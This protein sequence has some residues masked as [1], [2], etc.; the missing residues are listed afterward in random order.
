[1]PNH[2][3]GVCEDD[4]VVQ[5]PV[6]WEWTNPAAAGSL[7]N[8]MTVAAG[9]NFEFAAEL[10]LMR[11]VRVEVAKRAITITV[12]DVT[13]IRG[14][15]VPVFS[16]VVTEGSLVGGYIL[17]VTFIT[18][19]STV[20]AVGSYAVTATVDSDKY[21]VTVIDGRVTV[22]TPEEARRGCGAASVTSIR[23]GGLVALVFVMLSVGA[24]LFFIKKQRRDMPRE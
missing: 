1:M 19:V 7:T 22:V 5:I 14:S 12:G 4:I 13:M 11:E 3:L 16:F 8:T 23:G 10:E 21:A 20:S 9:G 2:T 24:V 15:A 18:S 17:N 6:M